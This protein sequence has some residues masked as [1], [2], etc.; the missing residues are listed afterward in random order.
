MFDYSIV[1]WMTFL[2]AAVLLNLSPGPDIAFTL[3]QTLRSGRRDGVAAMLRTT[4]WKN[5]PQA[6]LAVESAI[7]RA[8]QSL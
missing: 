1:H 5:S 4:C 6:L 8:K 3:G 7:N 2:S